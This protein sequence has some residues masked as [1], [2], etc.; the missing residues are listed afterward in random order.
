MKGYTSLISKNLFQ[1]LILKENPAATQRK[2]SASFICI[3]HFQVRNYSFFVLLQYF[4]CQSTI[5]RDIY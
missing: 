5:E 1:L 3:V 2:A 4:P